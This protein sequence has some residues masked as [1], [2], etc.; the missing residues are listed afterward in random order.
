MLLDVAFPYTIIKTT[1]KLILLTQF[2][3]F[4]S[5]SLLGPSLGSPRR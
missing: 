4:L 2:F 5:F 1:T 3:A